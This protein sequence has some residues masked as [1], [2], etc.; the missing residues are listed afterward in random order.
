M[1]KRSEQHDKAR[2]LLRDHQGIIGSLSSDE[3]RRIASIPTPAVE[4]GKTKP[5]AKS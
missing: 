3:L 2:E 1:N 4:I 5:Q